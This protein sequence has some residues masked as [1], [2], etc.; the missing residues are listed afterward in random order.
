[1]NHQPNTLIRLL[2]AKA[3]AGGDPMNAVGYAKAQFG[4]SNVVV[5]LLEK[6]VLG[7]GDLGSDPDFL[8]AGR[9]FMELVRSRSLIGKIAAASPF[10]KV[11]FE[12]RTLKQTGSTVAAWT[13]EGQPIPVTTSSFA[14]TKLSH[15]K[16]AG[17]VPMTAELLKG[18]GANF[19]SAM[20]RDLVRAVASLES[21]SFILPTNAGVPG[22][23]PASVT[24]GV[25]P[26]AAS[27]ATADALKT[28]VRALIKSFQGDL[29]TAVLVASPAMGVRLHLAGY[30][31][32]GAMG[33]EVL[34]IPLTTCSSVP[35][36]LL[37]L[38]DPSGILL[39]DDG[40]LM[41]LSE[42]STL[43]M[44]GDEVVS[45]WSENLAA[46]KATRIVNWLTSR[47]GSVAYIT[48]ADW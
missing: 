35:D 18:A 5:E 45:L 42:Q 46:I 43:T 40:V 2:Q 34:G 26:I 10:R 8:A 13:A 31:G 19:E 17:I 15:A 1:M 24:N 20:S 33:G 7:T 4:P 39:A 12:T 28:D 32:A 25:V 9:G 23:S 29:E 22:E 37:V 48:G 47:D 30:E 27:G 38:I 16:I 36:G 6:A 41:D 14:A 44:E 11:P 21:S 3:V